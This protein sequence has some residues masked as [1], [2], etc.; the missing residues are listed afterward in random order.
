MLGLVGSFSA[1]PVRLQDTERTR[2][3]L[4]IKSLLKS[5]QTEQ[6]QMGALPFEYKSDC[7]F[8]YLH[9]CMDPVQEV[10][11]VAIDTGFVYTAT[12]LP[13][14]GVSH[15][16]PQRVSLSHQRTS[17]VT[18]QHNHVDFTHQ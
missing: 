1:A 2:E 3:A 7:E 15:Q 13:P 10:S 11:H 5:F 18:L 6:A 8:Y 9:L 16:P 17:L 12:A 14:A 4:V